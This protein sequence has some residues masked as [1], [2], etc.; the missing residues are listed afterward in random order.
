MHATV[1]SDADQAVV[2]Q[3]EQYLDTLTTLKSRFLQTGDDGSSVQGTAW[4]ARP[5]R[6]RFEYDKPSPL[7]LVAGHGLVVF[8]DASLQQTSNI[9]LNQSPLGV[10]LGD[11]IVLHGDITVTDFQRLPGQYSL[12]LVRTKSPSDG[13][14]TLYV[15]QSPLMLTG[16]AV[17][18]AQG[19]ETR[20]RLSQIAMGG[21]YPDSLFTFIDPNFFE[22]KDS[23]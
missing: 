19:R 23:P 8:H 17:V 12:T 16:W 15:N 20:I 1:L 9:P 10:L 2:L 14:L 5:G 4:L 22:Q 3:I 13:T 21:S 6:M 18:D 11:H 7:L